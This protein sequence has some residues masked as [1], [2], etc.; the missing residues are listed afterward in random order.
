MRSSLEVLATRRRGLGHRRPDRVCEHRLPLLAAGRQ[1]LQPRADRHLRRDDRS[2][3]TARTRCSGKSWSTRAFARS[4][5]RG[6]RAAPAASASNARSRSTCV[7]APATTWSRCGRTGSPSD[8]DVRVDYEE[9]VG[10]CT[11]PRA[12]ASRDADA[13]ARGPQPSR[14][15]PGAA[16]HAGRARRHLL[17]DRAGRDPRRG[18]R[19]GR[20]QVAHRRG[21]HRPAR[22]ARADRRRR[23]PLRRPPHRQ[24]AVRAR[25]ARCAAARSARSSRTR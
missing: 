18:R 21:D 14:R 7:R 13:A 22:S 4:S 19:V 17:L 3:S 8:F 6:R 5:S 1:A 24:P 15:V 16:R 2:A 25:C 20:R 23:D 10:G 11:P 12:P 9:P